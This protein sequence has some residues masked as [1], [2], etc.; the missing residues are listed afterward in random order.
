MS[1]LSGFQS[2]GNQSQICCRSHICY[3]TYLV[4]FVLFLLITQ[5]SS[6]SGYYVLHDWQN[7]YSKEAS[8]AAFPAL[9]VS[10]IMLKTMGILKVLKDGGCV[11]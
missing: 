6:T 5:P 11:P 10:D 3:N 1:E 4:T 2:L 7:T 9:S 8:T